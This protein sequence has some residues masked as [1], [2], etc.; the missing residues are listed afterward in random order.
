M[1]CNNIEQLNVFYEKYQVPADVRQYV[2]R[3]FTKKEITFAIA[4]PE[5]FGVADIEEIFRNTEFEGSIQN[6]ENAKQYLTEEY[7]RG[8]INLVDETRTRWKLSDYAAFM[9]VYVVREYEDYVNRFSKQ[10]RKDIDIKYFNASFVPKEQHP[11]YAPTNDEVFTLQE[12][13]DFVDRKEGQI[14][15]NNCDC[16]SFAGDCGK[17]RLTCISYRGGINTYADRGMSKKLSKEEAK[18]MLRLFDKEGLMHTTNGET[19]CN[20]CGDCC[21]LSRGRER[22][23]SGA[24]WPLAHHIV[25]FD[26]EKCIGCGLCIRRCWLNVFDK[27]DGSITADVSKCV[28]CGLCVNTC[29]KNALAL[30]DKTYP[31]LKKRTE[32]RKEIQSH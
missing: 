1:D 16:R 3:L 7:Q 15:L 12:I 6:S 2:P 21:Y 11:E 13:L 29:P 8:F 30:E 5:N 14:Y 10:E 4:A 18:E 19:I 32:E 17:L 9:D 24:N 26:Q 22:L 31:G 20:C 23:G 28:G 27:K 25:K